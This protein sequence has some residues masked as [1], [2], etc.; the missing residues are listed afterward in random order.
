MAGEA[1]VG[2]PGQGGPRVPGPRLV[3]RRAVFIIVLAL[4]AASVPVTVLIDVVPGGWLLAAALL[5][6]AAARAL[7]PEYLCLGLLN[8]SRRQDAL[9]ML[10]LGVAIA[11]GVSVL[12]QG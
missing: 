4:V 11:V 9:T 6:G 10:L 2:V 8:R 5:L 3:V 1:G 7:L 12:P